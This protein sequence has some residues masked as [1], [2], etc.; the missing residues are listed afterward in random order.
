LLLT[1]IDSGSRKEKQWWLALTDSGT[2]ELTTTDTITTPG[3]FIDHLFRELD[4]SKPPQKVDPTFLL[5]VG[6]IY[7][8]IGYGSWSGEP[9]YLA[10]T[11][12]SYPAELD[13]CGA[14]LI[15]FAEALKAEGCFGPGQALTVSRLIRLMPAALDSTEIQL[16]RS[17]KTRQGMMVSNKAYE[18]RSGCRIR[19]PPDG[20]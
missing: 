13:L 10:D 16:C 19:V 11:F 12:A 4:E 7:H 1:A 6:G 8:A 5:R 3:E 2:Q 14:K 15:D 17:S 18:V 20:I 9:P